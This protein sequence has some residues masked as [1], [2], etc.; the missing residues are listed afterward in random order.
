MGAVYFYHLTRSSLEV[1]L[2]ELLKRALGVGWRV[3]VR[4]ATSAGME[5]LDQA[6]WLGDEEAF[7]AHGTAGGAH[8]RFQPIL[9]TTGALPEGF[10][11]LI[12]VEGAALAAEEVARVSRACLV[13]DGNDADAVAAARGQWKALT[14][15][16]IAAQYWAEDGGRWHM[17][18]ESAAPS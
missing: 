11:C 13:F 17:K 15:A 5:R 7:L 10:A 14:T 3:A 2:P 8:D 18:A 4:S 16:G 6:L 12:A 1:A 9:L